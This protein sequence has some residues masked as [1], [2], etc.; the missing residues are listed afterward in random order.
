MHVNNEWRLQQAKAESWT[1]TVGH[2]REKRMVTPTT[3]FSPQNKSLLAYFLRKKKKKK[4]R[5]LTLC[6]HSLSEIPPSIGRLK[7]CG[8]A[9]TGCSL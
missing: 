7:T 2:V 5:W 6:V 1:L 8:T 3:Q 4:K 9:T